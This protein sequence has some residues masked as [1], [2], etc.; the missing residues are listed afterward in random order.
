ME[1]I[2]KKKYS[3]KRFMHINIIYD[4][5]NV[6]YFYSKRNFLTFN[7]NILKIYLTK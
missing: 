1:K 4:L 3:V 7:V 6:N 5:T 2:V